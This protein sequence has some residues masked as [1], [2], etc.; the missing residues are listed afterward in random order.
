MEDKSI[1]DMRHEVIEYA[2]LLDNYLEEEIMTFFGFDAYDAS[3]HRQIDKERDIFYDSFLRYMSF[4]KKFDIIKK[5]VKCLGE[6]LY[7]GFES[8]K[9]RFLEIRNKFAH[10]LYPEVDEEFMPQFKKELV[11]LEQKDWEKM[12]TEAK[13][14]YKKIIEELDSKFYTK[15]PRRKK[16]RRFDQEYLLETI[17]YYEKLLEENKK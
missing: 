1:K 8:D 6:K 14:I 11:E 13:E 7:S 16:H 9:E 17:K 5:L 10:S 15:E 3:Y 12:Y 2:I 4:S